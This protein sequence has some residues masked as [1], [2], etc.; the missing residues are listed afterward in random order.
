MQERIVERF[1]IMVVDQNEVIAAFQIVKGLK[2]QRVP[3][4]G[5]DGCDIQ[6][7]HMVPPCRVMILMGK[8]VI[9]I[10]II[11]QTAR[12]C[13]DLHHNLDSKNTNHHCIHG[14]QDEGRKKIQVC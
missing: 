13:Y 3:I 10:K 5:D 9:S 14:G 2:Y 7:F 6:L 1:R 4:L 8:F 11:L 12:V